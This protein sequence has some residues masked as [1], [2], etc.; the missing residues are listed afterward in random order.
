MDARFGCALAR[1]TAPAMPVAVPTWARRPAEP[2]RTRVTMVR[3]ERRVEMTARPMR[4]VATTDADTP[5]PSRL[6]AVAENR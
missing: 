3:P 6:A 2:T 4:G 5:V 1:Q